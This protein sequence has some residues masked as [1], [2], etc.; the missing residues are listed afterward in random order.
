MAGQIANAISNVRLYQE[1]QAEK[2][3]ADLANRTKSVFLANMSHEIRTPLNAILGFTDVLRFDSTLTAEQREYVVIIH[4]SSQNLLTLI[5]G[6]LDLSKIEAGRMILNEQVFSIPSLLQNLEDRLSLQTVEKD[7]EMNLDISPDIPAVLYGDEVKLRQVLI[8]LMANA[9]RFTDQGC[10]TLEVRRAEP[11]EIEE[12]PAPK[13]A[14]PIFLRFSIQDTG[15]GL[16]TTDLEQIFDPFAPSTA[17]KTGQ[18]GPGLDLAISR[19]FVRMMG[20]DLQVTSSPGAGTEFIFSIALG[21]ENAFQSSPEQAIHI[22][23]L[24]PDQAI[25]RLLVMDNQQESRQWTVWLLTMMGYEVRQAASGAEAVQICRFYRPDLIFMD[26]DAPPGEGFS[27]TRQIKAAP[28]YRAA[29]IVALTTQTGGREHEQMKAAG[30]DD[31]LGK[32]L[33]PQEVARVMEKLLSLK[34]IVETVTEP[35][36]RGRLA[37]RYDQRVQFNLLSLP[38]DWVARYERAVQ[39]ADFEVVF[40]LIG[41]IRTQQPELCDYLSKLSNNFDLR[42]LQSLLSESQ[43]NIQDDQGNPS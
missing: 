5:N 35:V 24:A 29:R 7:L 9:V 14:A 31:I 3:S 6:I 11:D 38:P 27:A 20:G 39:T 22:P 25:P 33:D 43:A 2:Q 21:V 34:F 40:D 37:T 15:S 8:N 42:G 26:M 17:G 18:R 16:Q 36:M 41:Q 23:H 19:Q 28:E 13:Y 32:P 4:R 10:I 12:L 1:L 30:C